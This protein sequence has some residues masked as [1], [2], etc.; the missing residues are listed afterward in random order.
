MAGIGRLNL[1]QDQRADFRA[2]GVVFRARAHRVADDGA[3]KVVD[4]GR[5][6]GLMRPDA[7]DEGLPAAG[8]RAGQGR[9]GP[10]QRGGDGEEGQG[11]AQRA[12]AA[13]RVVVAAPFQVETGMRDG[14]GAGAEARAVFADGAVERQPG[15]AR[16]R[17]GGDALRGLPFAGLGRKGHEQEGEGG[18]PHRPGRP[19][20]PGRRLRR[21]SSPASS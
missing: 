10:W 16:H 13:L 19:V 1:L 18:L 8:E 7:V 12:G 15:C 17:I 11:A 21:F 9:L 6:D 20:L 2:A 14:A 5:V 4:H 3:H